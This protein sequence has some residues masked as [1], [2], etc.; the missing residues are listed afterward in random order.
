MGRRFREAKAAV[1][2]GTSEVNRQGS[3]ESG[4]GPVKVARRMLACRK[5]N[6]IP[7]NGRY[8]ST[9]TCCCEKPVPILNRPMGAIGNDESTHR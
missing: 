3:A 2:G 6:R 9:T 5:R 7:C 4:W 8:S 1:Q